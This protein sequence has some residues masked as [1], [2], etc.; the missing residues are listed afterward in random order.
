MVV[1]RGRA[2][3]QMCPAVYTLFLR[4]GDSAESLGLAPCKSP[5]AVHAQQ[6]P[7]GWWSGRWR[8]KLKRAAP[9]VRVSRATVTCAV[10]CVCVTCETRLWWCS[11]G[12]RLFTCVLQCTHFFADGGFCRVTWTCSLQVTSFPKGVTRGIPTPSALS[13]HLLRVAQQGSR[14][15]ALPLCARKREN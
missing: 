15:V 4:T 3:V 6:S 12:V 9:F 2:V 8:T 13:H 7:Q 11:V 10:H 1:Q 14:A 5:L